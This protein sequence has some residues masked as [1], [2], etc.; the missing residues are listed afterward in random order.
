LK[1]ADVVSQF[2]SAIDHL[3]CNSARTGWPSRIGKALRVLVIYRLLSPG[4]EWRLHRQWFG[5]KRPVGG[6]LV[7]GSGTR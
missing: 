5:S 7:D 3:K 2:G 4:S 6:L 1:R